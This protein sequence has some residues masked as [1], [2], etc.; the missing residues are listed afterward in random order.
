MEKA[1][2]ML[3]AL[4]IIVGPLV[5]AAALAYGTFQYRRRRRLGELQSTRQIVMLAVPVV[6]AVT[7]LTIRLMSPGSQ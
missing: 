3:W 7:R 1:S 6:I 5:L 2:G 4:Q